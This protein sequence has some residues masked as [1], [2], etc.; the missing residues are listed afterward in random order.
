MAAMVNG[1]ELAPS[2][3]DVALCGDPAL[4]LWVVSGRADVV[5]LPVFLDGAVTAAGWE[6][7]HCGVGEWVRQGVL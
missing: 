5:D 4:S 3:L 2:G 6:G 7:A 1:A